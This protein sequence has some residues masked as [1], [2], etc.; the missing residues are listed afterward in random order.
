MDINN[1]YTKIA[2]DYYL[3]NPDID[4][5]DVIKFVEITKF[6]IDKIW[7]DEFWKFINGLKFIPLNEK[8][9]D[10]MGYSTRKN[11]NIARNNILTKL[12][13]NFIKGEDYRECKYNLEEIKTTTKNSHG[14]HNKKHYEVTPDC[15]RNMLMMA[16]TSKAKEI[17]K[18]FISI[19]KLFLAYFEFQC[20]VKNYNYEKQI[21]E[22][23]KLQHIK[24]FSRDNEL[25]RIEDKLKN[26]I[27]VVYFIQ[28]GKS[29]YYK[30][31]FTH[32]LPDRLRALQTANRQYLSV[33]K[34]FIC[35]SSCI[36]E[37]IIHK[38]FKEYNVHGEWFK[39]EKSMIKSIIH[40][41][42]ETN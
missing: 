25:Q 33:Y 7:I 11:S 22:L 34:S 3:Q 27:G 21:E 6:P 20:L 41:Y 14:G 9:I 16:N 12:K 26:D 1:R 10:M 13:E 18:Y 19:E 42:I 35:H 5:K 28:E 37:T 36:L 15:F 38:D 8:R 23:K 39:L 31:G 29:K 4:L 32:D 40:K 17:R 24:E 2:Y 30:V